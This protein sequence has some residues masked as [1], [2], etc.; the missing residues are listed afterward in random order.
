MVGLTSTETVFPRTDLCLIY[1]IF[2]SPLIRR[3]WM[4]EHRVGQTFGPL[5]STWKVPTPSFGFPGRSHLVL[6]SAPEWATE[7][8]NGASELWVS[9]NRC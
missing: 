4:S 1:E 8:V 2:G 7:D 3:V 5:K 6:S 9:K